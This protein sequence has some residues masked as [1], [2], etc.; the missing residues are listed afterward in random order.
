MEEEEDGGVRF[1][2]LRKFGCDEFAA[3]ERKIVFVMMQRLCY[4]DAVRRRLVTIGRG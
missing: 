1:F 2:R 3:Y 4:K